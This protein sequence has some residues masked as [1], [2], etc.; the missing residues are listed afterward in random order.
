MGCLIMIIIVLLLAGAMVT[1]V[2]TLFKES[3][4]YADGMEALRKNE[5]VTD[6]LGIP[7]E[8][9]SMFQGNVH[10]SDDGGNADIKVPVKGSKGNATLLIIGEEINGKWNY[11]LM[12]VT[13]KST[14]ETID[15]LASNGIQIK[16]QD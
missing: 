5:L 8:P 11:Q 14:G 16:K 9:N 2:S 3:P 7:I 12:E 1:K 10:F 6:Q 4:P 13:I 15:L